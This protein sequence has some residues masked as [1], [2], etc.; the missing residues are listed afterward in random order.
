MAASGTLAARRPL[1]HY[2]AAAL[3]AVLGAG[4]I[5]VLALALSGTGKSQPGFLGTNARLLTDLNLVLQA[6]MAAAL[7]VGVVLVRRGNVR[8]H[9]YTMTLVVLSNLVLILRLAR[10]D[11]EPLVVGGES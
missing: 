9:Q 6:V 5:L 7:V 8:A 1:W 11:P 4:A 3:A 2:W 10:E